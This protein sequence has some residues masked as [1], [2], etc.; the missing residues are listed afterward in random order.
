MLD[1]R[2][3]GLAAAFD[4][5]YTRYADDLAFSGSASV[6]SGR[7]VALAAEIARDEGFLL[8]P[9]KTRVM[10]RAARQQLCGVVVTSIQT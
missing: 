6:A 7:L 1:R 10:P 9:S 8:N 3:T 4:A 5:R 2:L